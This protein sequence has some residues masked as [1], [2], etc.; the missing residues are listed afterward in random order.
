MFA[1]ADP[2]LMRNI[3]TF[4]RVSG[5][6]M[7]SPGFGSQTIPSRIKLVFSLA[8]TLFLTPAISANGFFDVGS[9]LTIAIFISELVIG[10]LL[11]AMFRIMVLSM[12]TSATIAAHS[13]SLSQMLGTPNAEPIPALGILYQ[14]SV[15]ALLIAIDFHIKIGAILLA[16]YEVFP[17]GMSQSVTSLLRSGILQINY[18]FE[19]AFS[20]AAPF[21]ALSLVYNF[22]IGLINRAMP[23]LMV[24]LIGAPAII[25][26]GILTLAVGFPMILDS[27]A[28]SFFELM[29]LKFEVE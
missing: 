21:V 10:L 24:Y 25:I 11:G 26:M 8:M 9:G 3:A 16:S 12:H 13:I 20:L 18:T 29:N 19:M 27:F 2:D 1:D 23:Q 15:I 4:L 17:L 28:I 22:I 5:F 6:L 14:W 7:V